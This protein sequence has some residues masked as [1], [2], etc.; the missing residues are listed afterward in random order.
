M[1]FK[2]TF[3]TGVYLSLNGAVY[4]NNSVILITEIG[5]TNTM[6]SQNERA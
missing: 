3:T 2:Y 5:E 6:P 4:V 1:V